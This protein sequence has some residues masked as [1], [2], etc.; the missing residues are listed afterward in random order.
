[1][2]RVVTGGKQGMAC[3]FEVVRIR[4]GTC[5]LSRVAEAS[6]GGGVAS[7]VAV[8]S[9]TAMHV[10]WVWSRAVDAR[11]PL[12]VCGGHRHQRLRF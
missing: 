10:R 12:H 5:V 6:E 9:R 7:D 1:M 3:I 8:A 2:P 4:D 11:A